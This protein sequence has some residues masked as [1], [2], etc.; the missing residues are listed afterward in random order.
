MEIKKNISVF[1]HRKYYEYITITGENL[2]VS[3]CMW[4]VWC[5]VCV[6]CV[7]IR[8]IIINEHLYIYI[9]VELEIYNYWMLYKTLWIDI[10]G[11]FYKREWLYPVVPLNHLFHFLYVYWIG[12]RVPILGHLEPV[13]FL[14]NTYI[15]S[16]VGWF[17]IY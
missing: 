10:G 17:I 11:E 7:C 12:D 9:D 1:S 16:H 8:Y 15:G 13:A 4:V 14:R 3:F 6:V 2:F 5:G